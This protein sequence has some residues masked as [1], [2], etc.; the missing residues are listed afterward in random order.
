MNRGSRAR[1]SPVSPRGWS[2]L[3]ALALAAALA[4]P[5]SARP[6][7]CVGAPNVV[8][9]KG[10]VGVDDETAAIGQL[11]LVHGDRSI[12]FAVVSAQRL[13]GGPAEDLQVLQRLGPG[14]PQIRVVGTPKTLAPL[15]EAKPGTTVE[16]RGVLDDAN[17]YMQLL[18]A[19]DPASTPAATA[20]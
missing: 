19:E 8:S 1:S 10:V 14:V 6:G 12:P 4:S 20:N 2:A 5:A 16:L 11:R 17:R 13:T 9:L 15:L 18:D 7:A 3:A